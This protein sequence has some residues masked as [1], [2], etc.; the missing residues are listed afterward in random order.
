VRFEIATMRGTSSWVG[1]PGVT[2]RAAS[3]QHA[4]VAAAAAV[5]ERAGRTPNWNRAKRAR[6]I[7]EPRRS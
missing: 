4:A 2:G 7:S 6:C 5:V 3:P 1:V